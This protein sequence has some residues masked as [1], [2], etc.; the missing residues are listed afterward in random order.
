MMFE[1]EVRKAAA[2]FEITLSGVKSSCVKKYLTA[3]SS[4]FVLRQRLNIIS[5]TCAKSCSII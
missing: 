1:V 5:S 4:F 3:G 2:E